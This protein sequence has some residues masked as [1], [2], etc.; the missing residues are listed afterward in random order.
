MILNLRLR[1][2][3]I[4]LVLFG[5]A[6][7][8]TLAAQSPVSLLD[9]LTQRYTLT[10]VD[11]DGTVTQAG[12]VVSTG[13]HFLRANPIYKDR[14]QP[15]SYKKGRVS[16][17]AFVKPSRDNMKIADS[18]DYIT[19]NKLL[20]ITKIEVTDRDVTFSLQ[21]CAASIARR[22][23]GAI[24][25]AALSFQFPKGSVNAGNLQQIQNTIAEVF[26]IAEQGESLGGN[27]RPARPIPIET[28]SPTQLGGQAGL[29]IVHVGQTVEEVKALLG[30]PDRIADLGGKVIYSYPGL[31]ITFVDGKVSSVQ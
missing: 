25:R 20:Y 2:Q 1:T 8:S 23:P 18:L 26:T 9:Q 5:I 4:S 12:T 19:S 28:A 24:Y 3:V 31:K 10:K 13:Q 7:S 16:Q 22:L 21:T 29:G 30:Q 27:A 14:Y 15:N 6:S 11:P 17:P